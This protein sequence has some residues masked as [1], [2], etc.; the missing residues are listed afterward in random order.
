MERSRGRKSDCKGEYFQDVRNS[1]GASPGPSSGPGPKDEGRKA[2][3]LRR[4]KFN[5]RDE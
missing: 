2:C 3:V 5:L 1:G 4:L